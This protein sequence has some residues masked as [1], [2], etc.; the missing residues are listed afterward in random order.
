ML[1][2]KKLKKIRGQIINEFPT[3]RFTVSAV[4]IETVHF[5]SMRPS[6][7]VSVLQQFGQGNYDLQE[8]CLA[9]WK[10]FQEAMTQRRRPSYSMNPTVGS[11]AS[12]ATT[13]DAIKD[14]DTLKVAHDQ[15]EMPSEKE[16]DAKKPKVDEHLTT[17]ETDENENATK[18][19]TKDSPEVPEAQSEQV[20]NT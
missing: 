11:L 8:T 2:G 12:S 17:T 4:L 10:K 1:V 5:T 18:D 6:R 20:A 15:S 13:S 19:D 3:V 7:L 9:I 16:P 14:N